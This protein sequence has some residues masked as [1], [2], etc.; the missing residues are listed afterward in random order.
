[1]AIKINQP[2][3]KS[4]EALIKGLNSLPP[5]LARSN[6]GRSFAET[7]NQEKPGSPHS[8]QHPV[9][10]VGLQ[11][12][13]DSGLNS[14]KQI[15][16][17]YLFPKRNEQEDDMAAEVAYDENEDSH[18]F[19]NTEESDFV[20]GTMATLNKARRLDRSKKYN[21]EL[22]VLKIPAIYVYV[23][24][25]KDE[26]GNEDLFLPIEPTIEPLSAKEEYSNDEFIEILE[27]AAL[28]QLEA[29]QAIQLPETTEEAYRPRRRG[30]R[31]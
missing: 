11:D 20:G 21:Y 16:W 6:R 19:L 7:A 28:V 26:E 2:P 5:G 3:N 29:Q 25:L 24:W 18:N 10:T 22:R 17:R 27:K 23:L 31:N 14:A 9:Y 8:V 1:M 15:S 4:Q 13:V 30:N 12:L